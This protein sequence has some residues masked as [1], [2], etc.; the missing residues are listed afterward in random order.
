MAY[1]PRPWLQENGKWKKGMPHLSLA[2][3]G[4]HLTVCTIPILLREVLVAAAPTTRKG[5]HRCRYSPFIQSSDGRRGLRMQIG[6]IDRHSGGLVHDIEPAENS[7]PQNR[8]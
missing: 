6:S 5:L 2:L 8:L 4:R 1:L 3:G 7:S